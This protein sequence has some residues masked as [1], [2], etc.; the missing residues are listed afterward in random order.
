MDPRPCTAA[1][2]V[3]RAKRIVGKGG[4]YI[5]GTGDYRPRVVNGK[6]IDLPWTW[7]SS[8]EGSDCAGFA[9]SWCY[10]LRRRRPGFASGRLPDFYRDQS[11]VDDDINCNS[12][13]EDALTVRDCF[14]V[15][16]RPELGALLVYPTLRITGKD[17]APHTFIGHVGIVTGVSRCLE[18]DAGNPQYHL[19]DIAQCRGPNGRK[20]GVVATD[21]SLWDSHDRN[22][23]K[24]QHRTVML[25]AV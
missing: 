7:R 18:W 25:A 22:W 6:L 16:A 15:I 13:I 11:D 9:I 17:G 24:P 20:P 23:P 21:G 12:A 14:R 5:L 10:K 4:Q 2:A 1:E 8:E 19:L 3:E